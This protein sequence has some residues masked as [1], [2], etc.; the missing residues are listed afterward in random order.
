MDCP[1][2]GKSSA[3]GS[4]FCLQCGTALAQAPAAAHATPFAG[5]PPSGAAPTGPAPTS[6]KAIASLVL[7]LCGLLC[8]LAAIV[9]LIYGI[10]ALSDINKSGGRLEGRGLATAGIA[11]SAVMICLQVIFTVVILLSQ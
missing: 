9:G 1:Q 2:C 8:G 4:K 7:G 10:I 11:V 6:G 3:N 5:A